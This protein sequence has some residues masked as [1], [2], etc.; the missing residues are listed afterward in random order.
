[1]EIKKTYIPSEEW[2]NQLFKILLKE[3][4]IIYIINP[5]IAGWLVSFLLYKVND[6]YTNNIFIILGFII[7][8][9]MI[10][11]SLRKWILKANKENWYFNEK[12]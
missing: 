4:Y 7:W 12:V 2:L 5:I 1:M 8:I 3:R 6:D 11:I 9:I 10:P